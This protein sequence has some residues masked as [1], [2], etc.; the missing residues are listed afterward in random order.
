MPGRGQRPREWDRCLSLFLEDC[1]VSV[2][3]ISAARLPLSAAN[4]PPEW[5]Q[6]HSGSSF[7]MALP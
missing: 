4:L 5:A 1:S 3:T 2:L 7:A 6:M